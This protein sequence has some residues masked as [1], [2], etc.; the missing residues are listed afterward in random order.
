MSKT[1]T[2][3]NNNHCFKNWAEKELFGL[4]AKVGGTGPVLNLVKSK[5]NDSSR[6]TVGVTLAV[7]SKD[8]NKALAINAKTLLDAVAYAAQATIKICKETDTNPSQVTIPV[9]YSFASPFASEKHALKSDQ[10]YLEETDD[11]AFVYANNFWIGDNK[12][13]NSGATESIDCTKGFDLKNYLLTKLRVIN[14]DYK[15]SGKK[16]QWIFSANNAPT[17]STNITND[18]NM[19]ASSAATRAGLKPN[20]IYIHSVQGGGGNLNIVITD[21]DSKISEVINTEA[22]GKP[23]NSV[24]SDDEIDTIK[25]IHGD[26]CDQNIERWTAGGTDDGIDKIGI[27]ETVRHLKAFKQK[28]NTRDLLGKEEKQTLIENFNKIKEALSLKAGGILK[29]KLL[30][31]DFTLSNSAVSDAAN[32]GDMLALALLKHQNWITAETIKRNPQLKGIQGKNQPDQLSYHGGT[33][34]GRL[35]VLEVNEDFKTKLGINKLEKH[36]PDLDGSVDLT[37]AQLAS[38]A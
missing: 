27:K 7:V 2:I 17:I 20:Q 38:K 29:S 32:E 4:S 16:G 24:F 13:T 33:I 25:L 21:A 12:I 23:L 8:S 11:N 34:S 35:E 36:S 5:A 3:R 10:S 22:F 28:F 31:E 19:V 26:R 37:E 1:A 30:K 14:P 9:N 6:R 15:V 18:G